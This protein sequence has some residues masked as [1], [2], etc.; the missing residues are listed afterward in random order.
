MGHDHSREANRLSVE[1]NTMRV[2]REVSQSQEPCVQCGHPPVSSLQGRGGDQLC[3]AGQWG[4]RMVSVT[5]SHLE[6]S[7]PNSETQA[8]VRLR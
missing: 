4:F 7:S 6:V 5:L 3:A 1:M 8:T 2:G